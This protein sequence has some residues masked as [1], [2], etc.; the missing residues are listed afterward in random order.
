MACNTGSVVPV[1]DLGTDTVVARVATE[2]D[3]CRAVAFTPDNKYAL[4]TLERNDSVAVIDL[5]TYQ[6]TRYI[7]VGPGPR[8][9]AVHDPD[10]VLYVSAFSRAGGLVPDDRRQF[11]AHS[12]TVVD[13][14]GVDLANADDAV[15]YAE[16]TV[17]FGPCSVTVFDSEKVAFQAD[18]LNSAMV[19]LTDEAAANQR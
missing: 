17:G 12:V 15:R 16:L 4:A 18:K 11:M 3:G 13:F 19:D 2:I 9:I 8:G 10:E 7:P 1:I 6:V 14:K 5:D